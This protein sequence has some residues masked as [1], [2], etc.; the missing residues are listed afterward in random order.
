MKYR[1]KPVKVEAWQW[2]GGGLE[3]APKWV[4]SARRAGILKVRKKRKKLLV[5]MADV[6]F[7][8]NPPGTW[9]VLRK[10]ASGRVSIQAL[11]EETFQHA[12]EP[13]GPGEYETKV[14]AR[15]TA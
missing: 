5:K 6:G 15:T 8:S 3:D 2:C 12:F 9:L 4:E 7:T 11:S 13:V 10:V 1:L 14:V